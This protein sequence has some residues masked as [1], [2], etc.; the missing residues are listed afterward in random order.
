MSS[1]MSTAEQSPL[2]RMLRSATNVRVT[3][4]CRY[5]VHMDVHV[6]TV[7]IFL[8]VHGMIWHVWV[9]RY[10]GLEI[11][12]VLCDC[13]MPV[14]RGTNNTFKSDRL[15]FFFFWVAR[16]FRRNYAV[17][18]AFVAHAHAHAHAHIITGYA[19]CIV[20]KLFTQLRVCDIR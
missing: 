20:C 13:G 2:S 11:F 17:R 3:C 8:S 4:T 19:Q 1:Q 15:N 12:V 6:E 18:A 10:Y 7:W 9:R 5:H 14:Q 16:E